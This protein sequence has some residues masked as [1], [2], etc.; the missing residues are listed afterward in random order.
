MGFIPTSEVK[1]TRIVKTC[2]IL[3]NWERNDELSRLRVTNDAVLD[4]M[5]SHAKNVVNAAM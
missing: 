4:I 5:P 1:K 2:R 3:V